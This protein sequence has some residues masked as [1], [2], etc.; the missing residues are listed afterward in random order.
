MQ[1]VWQTRKILGDAALR[2]NV[3]AVRVP[4]FYG[5]GEAVHLQTR[6][7]LGAAQAR[8]L[9]RKAPGVSVMDE[10]EAGGYP[11]AAT[12]AAKRDTV[13][14]GGNPGYLAPDR[15][16]KLLIFAGNVRKRA[17]PNSG[18]IA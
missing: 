6:R 4:V 8:E 17:A 9:L 11:P 7:A 13:Y 5:H 16:L 1:L 2:M 14:V 3:T 10:P 15:G 18:Q 12:E